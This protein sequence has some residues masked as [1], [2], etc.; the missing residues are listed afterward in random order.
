MY[1]GRNEEIS[2]PGGLNQ[3]DK[4]PFFQIFWNPG[5]E[6]CSGTHFDDN[7]SLLCMIQVCGLQCVMHVLQCVLHVLQC[8]LHVLQC[9]LHV[10]ESVLHVLQ[11][12]LHVLRVLQTNIQRHA[13][14]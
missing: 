7:P 3:K 13:L 6:T 5:I 14:R 8:V 12:V 4:G 11:C 2:L 9:V 10:L 1:T